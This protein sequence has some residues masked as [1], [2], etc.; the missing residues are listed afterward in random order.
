MDWPHA[1]KHWTFAPGIYMVTAGTYQKLPHMNTPERLDYVLDALLRRAAE[2]G[3]TLEAWSVLSNHYHFIGRSPDEPATLRRFL[4]KL[5]MQTA[6]ELNLRDGTPGRKVWHQYR[7]THITFERSYLAR[8]NYVHNNPLHHGAAEHAQDYRW[9]SA[10][11]FEQSAPAALVA[12]VHGF[13]TDALSI[14][15]DY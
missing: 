12:T 7:D 4:G 5:H 6:K 3:W 8:L 15:D 11:W 9:C 2:F 13:K 14:A 10:A 1:P